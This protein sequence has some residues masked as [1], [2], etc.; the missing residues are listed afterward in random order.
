[1]NARR[2]RGTARK[3]LRYRLTRIV[4]AYLFIA[5]PLW[6]LLA[7]LNPLWASPLL[8][9]SVLFDVFSCLLLGVAPL[10]GYWAYARAIERRVP[11][12]ISLR[13]AGAEFGGGALI[14]VGMVSLMIGIL[15]SMNVYRQLGVD[16]DALRPV[17][18]KALGMALSSGITEEL[19][20]RAVLFRIV[21]ERW[22]TWKALGISAAVFGLGH[23]F[24]RNASAMS[25]INIALEAGLLLAAAYLLTRRIW[26]AAGLHAAWNFSEAAIYGV[27][28]S[29]MTGQFLVRARMQ[30]PAWLTGGAFGLE[31]S[32]VSVAVCL[33][34]FAVLMRAAIKKRRVRTM[35]RRG[36]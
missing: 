26:L 10:A 5:L 16:V 32:V 22:G 18:N 1:M 28:V 12:E 24:N 21:E 20:F 19:V 34:V 17:L 7:I 15:Y 23:Q 36:R 14:G 4:L 33:A 9:D 8:A 11:A 3:L 29:G 35:P 27:A 2:V 13:G 25:G 6:P 31:D 30:G